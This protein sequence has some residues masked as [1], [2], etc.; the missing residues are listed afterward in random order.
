[1]SKH[2]PAAVFWDMDGTLVDTEPY[3][4]RAE[5]ELVAQFGGTW[6][7]TKALS[8]VG[9]SLWRTAEALQAEGVALEAGLII[10]TLT[11]RVLQQVDEQFPWRP[12]AEELLRDLR[13]HAIPTALVTMSI[14]RMAERVADSVPFHAF[15]TIVSLDD[16]VEGKPHPEP[17]QRAAQLLGVPIADTVALEDSPTG[18]AS[19][20]AAGTVT[21]GVPH[22]LALDQTG[23]DELWSTLAGKSATDITETFSRVRAL[24]APSTVPFTSDSGETQ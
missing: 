10:Q 4:M 14:R 19:A 5:H 24:H 21:I 12:G 3:W 15:D 7:T 8:V 23:A 17:Y 18:V 1:M 9:K 2:P 22:M 13:R 16:V 20:V 11:D 6:D